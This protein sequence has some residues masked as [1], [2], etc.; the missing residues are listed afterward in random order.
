LNHWTISRLQTAMGS[1]EMTGRQVIEDCLS[2]IDRLDRGEGGLRAILEINPDAILLAMRLDR[3]RSQG[4][5]RGPFHGIPLVLKAN[6]DTADGM[7]TTAGSLAL[8]G[9]LAPRDAFLVGKL[10]SAGAVILGKGNLSEWANFR[11]AHSVSGWSSLGGQTRNPHDR[12]RSPCGSSSGS[13]V[14]VAAG[15][16]PVSVGTETDGSIVCPAQTCGVVGIKPT[17]GLISRSGII[18]IAHSQDTAGPM[19]SCVK[20]AALLLGLLA[21]ADAR[22]AATATIPR[23]HD[24]DFVSTLTPNGLRNA[25]IGVARDCFGRHPK[26]DT[27]IEERLGLLEDLGAQLIDPAAIETSGTWRGTELDVLLYEFKHGLNAYLA[28]LGDTAP[29]R[30]L[31]EIIEFNREH[32]D[33]VMPTFGQELMEQAQEKGSLADKAY[34]DALAANH[35]L[36]RTEGI[37]ATLKK[38]RLDALVAPTGT[39]AWLIDHVLGDFVLGGC[40]SAPAVAGY[41]HITVPAGRIEGLPVGLSFFS[42]AWQEAK[43]LRYAYAF[44]CALEQ[45][46]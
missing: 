42:T 2:R 6:I 30:T 31:E 4:H 33:L 39:P 25:R 28:G 9:N 21:G 1:G 41:P 32:A 43:L 22:D 10:R 14:S 37:D 8:K 44:E 27:L 29:V 45:T 16:C 13:A 24:S 3:E 12:L 40:S 15:F 23:G 46:A 20:D 17:V 19:A 36:A 18:P 38:H 11:G 34:V 26:V 7:M 5:V 35:R